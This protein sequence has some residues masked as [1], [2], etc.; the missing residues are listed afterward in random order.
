MN[1]SS[2]RFSSLL[3]QLKSR[4]TWQTATETVL[5]GFL[6]LTAFIGN[7]LCVVVYIK[8]RHCTPLNFVILSL[9]AKDLLQ[10]LIT[11]PVQLGV[12]VAGRWPFNT[13]M[14]RFQGFLTPYFHQVSI[15]TSVLVA[16]GVFMAL[17]RVRPFRVIS[18]LH[19]KLIIC[20]G[21]FLSSVCVLVFV[22]Q[23]NSL[24]FHPG[25]LMCVFDYRTMDYVTAITIQIIFTILPLAAISALVMSSICSFRKRQAQDI[26]LCV[27]HD[28]TIPFQDN[29][30]MSKCTNSQ[31]ELPRNS[32]PNI[33]N[34]ILDE[35]GSPQIDPIC[36]MLTTT[37]GNS[38]KGNIKM[39]EKNTKKDITPGNFIISRRKKKRRL[40]PKDKVEDVV[41]ALIAVNVVSIICYTVSLAN[42]MSECVLRQH[43]SAGWAYLLY[44][45]IMSLRG[46]VTP[47]LYAMF[48][49]AFRAEVSKLF[50]VE[51]GQFR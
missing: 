5:F 11:M 50:L 33:P 43:W 20:C 28:N 36:I 12:L 46:V 45:L 44:C 15:F 13:L 16:V 27:S 41:K 34:N 42:E 7:F 24:V 35:E 17:S 22:L 39:D 32:S 14:C 25:K 38:R 23:G 49:P 21:W 31:P 40:K 8:K 6:T 26:L 9:A 3:F 1:I 47:V 18:E 10:C 48:N 30:R 29:I 37:S 19:I 51:T 2:A 4:S